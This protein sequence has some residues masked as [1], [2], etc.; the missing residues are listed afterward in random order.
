M[1]IWCGTDCH[2]ALRLTSST[3]LKIK[4]SAPCI[5]LCTCVE[6]HDAHLLATALYYEHGG[7][8][9]FCLELFFY[10]SSLSPR[11]V[12]RK[13]HFLETMYCLCF[14]KKHKCTEIALCNLRF[15]ANVSGGYPSSNLCINSMFMNP[16]FVSLCHHLCNLLLRQ[17]G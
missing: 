1:F 6:G 15:S 16:L 4:Y 10:F 12:N 8:F 5:F 2:Y 14:C 7:C 9:S 3:V 13:T 11:H 17:P